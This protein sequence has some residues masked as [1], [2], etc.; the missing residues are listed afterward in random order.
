[1]IKYHETNVEIDVRLFL[2][3]E[4]IVHIY[5]DQPL[6]IKETSRPE[7]RYEPAEYDLELEDVPNLVREINNR[8]TTYFTKD[9]HILRHI[10]K[11]I[12]EDLL[13]DAEINN[14]ED[15]VEITRD[16]DIEGYI[17]KGGLR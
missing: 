1:M 7:N 5:G 13:E 3:G 9:N 4:L 16:I 12:I 14:P 6:D 15:T 2:E 8:D 11:N 17:K 10:V